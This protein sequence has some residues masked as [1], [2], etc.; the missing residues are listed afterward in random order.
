[1]QLTKAGL[2]MGAGFGP[3]QA[4]CPLSS[5]LLDA[6]AMARLSREQKMICFNYVI[7]LAAFLLLHAFAINWDMMKWSKGM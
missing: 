3:G 2:D 6:V 5:A 4:L 1:M 7:N